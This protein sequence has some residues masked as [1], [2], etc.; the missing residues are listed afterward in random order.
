MQHEINVPNNWYDKSNCKA[1]RKVDNS[2]EWQIILCIQPQSSILE[3]I[4]VKMG[5]LLN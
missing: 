4:E 1:N 5:R 2:S 3:P